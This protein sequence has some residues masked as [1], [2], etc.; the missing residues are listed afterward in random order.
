M[1]FLKKTETTAGTIG[2]WLLS[3]TSSELFPLVELSNS[4]KTFFNALKNERRRKEYLAVRA[5]L[6]KL[7]GADVNITYQKSG[8][9]KLKNHLANISISHSAD[10]AVV[11]ISE[12]YIGIDVENIHRKISHITRRFLSPAEM[13]QVEQIP[14]KQLMQIIYWSAKEAIFKC[15][16]EENI[17]FNRQINI[18]P[19]NLKEEGKFSAEL[20][21]GEHKSHFELGYFLVENNVVVYCVEL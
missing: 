20:T 14:D 16:T 1:P 8:R 2:I 7:T 15:T 11:M 10:M 6:K 4:E 3:E 13:Q 12:K 5:L 21:S 18:K 19:F 9:P 17:Q